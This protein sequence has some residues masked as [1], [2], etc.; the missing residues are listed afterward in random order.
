MFPLCCCTLWTKREWE[1]KPL[2]FT[3]GCHPHCAAREWTPELP[4]KFREY[5]QHQRCVAIGECGVDCKKMC[6][7]ELKTQIDVFR[8]QAR[9]AVELN[10]PLVIHAREAE[11][12]TLEVRSPGTVAPDRSGPVRSG[13]VRFLRRVNYLIDGKRGV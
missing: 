3:V 12:Y 4:K 7:V 5:A 8:I 13:Q 9:L 2:R 11:R 10:K 1:S 6:G